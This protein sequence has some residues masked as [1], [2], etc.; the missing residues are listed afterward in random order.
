MHT[1]NHVRRAVGTV[2]GAAAVT[3]VTATMASAHHCYKVEWNENSYAHHVQGGT[4]WMPLSDIGAMIISEEIGLPQCAYVADA[5]VADFMDIKGLTQE[6]LVHS[7]A[8]TGG[9]AAHQ[10]KT[11][12]PFNYLVEEDFI[13]LEQL[14]GAA[15]GECMAT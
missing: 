5:V 8:T 3:L 7:R 4:A 6:P 11:V 13:L 2:A 15:V 10:G 14:M 12:K 9:G 1:R